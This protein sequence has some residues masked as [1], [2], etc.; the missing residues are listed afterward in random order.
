MKEQTK[1]FRETFVKA[2]EIESSH[3]ILEGIHHDASDKI[4]KS[5]IVRDSSF[6]N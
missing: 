6:Q 5:L 3:I 2:K 4:V 1:D